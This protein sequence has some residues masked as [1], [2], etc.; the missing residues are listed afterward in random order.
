MKAMY[1]ADVDFKDNKMSGVIKKCEYIY[2]AIKKNNIGIDFAY[3]IGNYIIIQN[4]KE[5]I[6]KIYIT[7]KDKYDLI[8]KTIND[9]ECDLVFIRYVL[10]DIFFINFLKRIKD[11][12]AKII[13][14]FPTLPYDKERPSN[15]IE[16][17]KYFRQYLKKY[18]DLAVT[19]ND[20]DTAFGIR[21]VF[22][23]NGI[24]VS[25]QKILKYRDFNEDKI[26][27][28]G[29]ANVSKWHGYDRVIMGIAEYIRITKKNNVKFYIVGDGNE[30]S[31]LIKL[32]SK[33]H[34]SD[35]IKFFGFKKDKELDKIYELADI[36]I[37][38]LSNKR[39]NMIDSSALKNREYCSKGLP[40]IYA[41]YDSDFKDFKYSLQINDDETPVDILKVIEFIKNIKTQKKDYIIDMRKYAQKKLDWAKKIKIV[42]NN[43]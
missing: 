34:I 35:S 12:G 26:N 3:K 2:N 20:I 42:L 5:I 18:V 17:D 24:E 32:S 11:L 22:I 30:I 28:I 27:L 1:F 23:G 15:I 31:N 10:S 19:Y 40:F 36:G 39:K 13:L 6:K 7:T 29:V 43:I 4:D 14:E 38:P 21:N 16:I 25:S 41:G 33:L 37:G 9:N 8:L